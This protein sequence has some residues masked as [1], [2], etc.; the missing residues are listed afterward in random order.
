MR[1]FLLVGVGVI[2]L[3]I[4]GLMLMPLPESY[5][6]EGMAKANR[7]SFRE[8]MGDYVP[9]ELF[10]CAARSISQSSRE[11]MLRHYVEQRTPGPSRTDL[12]RFSEESLHAFERCGVSPDEVAR[13]EIYI[14]GLVAAVFYIEDAR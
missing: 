12:H 13:D 8:R 1:K 2:A 14:Q 4:G 9:S 3:A 6:A 7:D 11:E 10:L 5:T